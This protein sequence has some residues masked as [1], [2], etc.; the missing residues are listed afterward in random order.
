MIGPDIQLQ[1]PSTHAVPIIIKTATGIT[2]A[3]AIRMEL[4]HVLR[5]VGVRVMFVGNVV[6]EMDPVRG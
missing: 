6:E 4:L 3:L 1:P 2:E 5:A